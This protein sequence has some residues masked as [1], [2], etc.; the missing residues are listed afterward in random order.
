MSDTLN[1]NPEV[2]P[3]IE[4]AAKSG[5]L[6]IFIGAGISRLA[7]CPSWDEF[8]DKVLDELTPGCLNYHEKSLLQSI[9]DPRKRL[10][11]ARIIEKENKISVDYEKI[12]KGD[13]PKDNIYKYINNFR[14]TFV[15]TNYDLLIKPESVQSKSEEYWRFHNRT[16]LLNNKLDKQGNVIHIH[17]CVKKPEKMIITT[18]NYLDHYTN[19]QVQ[20]FLQHLF[21]TKTVLFLGYGL[22]EFEILEYILKNSVGKGGIKS[23]NGKKSFVL[24]GFFDA[25]ESLYRNLKKYYMDSF[26]IG[27][28]GFKRDQKDYEQ[29]TDILESWAGNI[30]F[31][32]LALSDSAK[33]MGDELDG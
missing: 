2:P 24:Q 27:L 10:S 23:T 18:K 32:P 12:L 28:I 9:P 16:D 6:V 3:E 31:K 22:E 19:K 30:S 26:S 14:C 4:K 5:M 8:A 29:Q 20:T 33:F 13:D 15:T 21:K 1:L 7:G 25:E 17:G 11:I